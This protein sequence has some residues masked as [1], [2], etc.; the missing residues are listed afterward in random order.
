MEELL[1]NLEWHHLVFIFSIVFIL[2]FRKPLVNLISRVTSIDK[3]GLKTTPAPEA[4]RETEKKEAVQELLAEISSS[5]VL[6]DIEG[7]IKTNLEEKGL[8]TEGDTTRVLI[9]HL[10]A[11]MIL[12]EFEQIYNLIFGT[13]ISLL[14]KLNEVVGQGIS[15]HEVQLYFS[16]VQ[17]SHKEEFGIWSLDQYLN[18]LI[19]RTLI[20]FKDGSY[21]ITN[22]GVEYL[23]WMARNGKSENKWF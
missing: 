16:D 22:L 21:H 13:Q 4:Q 15:E 3:S 7:K 20:L 10:A 18:F 1:T 19:E 17:E 23:T 6:E 11:T 14:K 9:K 12:L 5:I 8:G 2:L